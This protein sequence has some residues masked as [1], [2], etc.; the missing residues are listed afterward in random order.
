MVAAGSPSDLHIPE[1]RSW[2]LLLVWAASGF[3][4]FCSSSV[5]CIL[6]YS[7]PCCSDRAN[8][9]ARCLSFAALRP[10]VQSVPTSQA[11][12]RLFGLLTVAVF[13]TDS[14][15]TTH[16]ACKSLNDISDKPEKD[17]VSHHRDYDEYCVNTN[18]WV[19]VYTYI[20]FFFLT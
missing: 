19:N 11:K 13:L 8:C 6:G 20:S 10:L 12:V 9:L 4:S 14:P 2:C 17:Q 1:T 7:P 5:V 3:L 16:R 15:T 18:S